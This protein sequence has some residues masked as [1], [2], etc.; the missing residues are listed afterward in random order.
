MKNWNSDF[1]NYIKTLDEEIIVYDENLLEEGFVILEKFIE[2][3]GKK[4]SAILSC[5]YAN[6]C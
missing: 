3:T 1:D 5:F 6:V 2:E 4:G